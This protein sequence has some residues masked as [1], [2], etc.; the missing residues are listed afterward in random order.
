[1]RPAANEQQRSSVATFYAHESELGQNLE[2]SVVGKK[3]NRAGTVFFMHH[4]TA[5]LASLERLPSISCVPRTIK[6][7]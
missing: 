5:I 7:E 2:K 6:S 1:M 3:I 4:I